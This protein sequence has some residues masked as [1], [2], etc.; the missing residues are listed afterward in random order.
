VDNEVKWSF[1]T[2]QIM[3][4]CQRQ[5]AFSSLIASP[6]ARDSFR[7]E[8]YVLKQLQELPAWAG[9]A[10]HRIL[11]T[12][13]L[14]ALRG[15]RALDAAALAGHATDLAR[16]RFAFSAARR[17]RDPGVTKAAA[18][19]QY[20][21]LFEHEYGREVTPEVLQDTIDLMARCFFQLASQ[22]EF[23]E[24]LYRGFGYIA[25]FALT[26]PLDEAVVRAVPDLVFVR[27]DGG[28]TVI[29]WKV[30]NSDSSDYSRQMLVNAL[31]VLRS[32]RWPAA[33]PE[34]IRLYE[35]NLVKNHIREH[36]ITSTRLD[37]AEDFIFRSLS[38]LKDLIG[39][40]LG[41]E[42]VLDDFGVAAR[43][44]TCAHCAFNR[45]CLARLEAAT[46]EAMPATVQVG[47]W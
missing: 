36:P 42:V 39:G 10:V 14:I 35:V 27:P 11:A 24:D 1:S 9:N 3:R 7:Q 32:R 15:R 25:E 17:Y 47:L 20:S 22:S 34:D 23:L 30:G 13:F 18:G 43:P 40:R 5:L 33:R 38:E 41:D 29:D 37:E 28:P 6:V 8:A 44:G 4:R 19:E 26:F 45:L 31:A 46:A 2:H 12:D 21:A 16:S